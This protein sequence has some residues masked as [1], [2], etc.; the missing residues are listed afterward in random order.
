MKKSICAWIVFATL[1]AGPAVMSLPAASAQA[2]GKSLGGFMAQRA[3]LIDALQLD[4]RQQT[5]LD[6]ITSEMLPKYLAL[7]PMDK[8]QRD[9]ARR[10]LNLQTQQKINAMLTPD[11]QARYELLQAERTVAKEKASM[12][13]KA[14]SRAPGS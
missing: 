1:L 13:G 5:K 10:K 14:S 3:Q 6:A 2:Q 7:Q 9:P 4:E 11:Q 12:P 8:A